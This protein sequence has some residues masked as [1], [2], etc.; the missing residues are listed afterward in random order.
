VLSFS[1]SVLTAFLGGISRAKMTATRLS[2]Q[3]SSGPLQDDDE[4]YFTSRQIHTC[5]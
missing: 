1:F 3:S 5:P 4:I 2:Q